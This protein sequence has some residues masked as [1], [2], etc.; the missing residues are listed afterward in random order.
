[1][2]VL[3]QLQAWL[4]S[5]LGGVTLSGVIGTI[6]FLVLKGAFNKTISKINVEKIVEKA[7]DKGT[8][9]VKKIAF[10]QSIQPVVESELKKITE[11]AN[12]Y[13]K[14]QLD[15]MEE[16]Y[17]KII[18]V[19]EKLS[20]YFDNSIG[21]SEEAKKELKVALEEAKTNKVVNLQEVAVVENNKEEKLKETKKEEVTQSTKIER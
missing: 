17:D 1:M 20:A 13:I 7:T 2:E 6:I 5:I 10:T 3:T 8:E 12:T 15:L 18:V 16:K 19:L 14:E 11:T 21:V 4:L 9:K